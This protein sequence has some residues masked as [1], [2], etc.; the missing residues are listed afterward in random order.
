MPTPKSASAAK[1]TFLYLISF[2]A[3]GFVA[4]AVGSLFFEIINYFFPEEIDSWKNEFSQSQLKFS[5]ASLIIT[6]PIYFF[7]NR[8]INKGL[9]KKELNFESGVRKWLTYI[10]LFI[11]SAILVGDLISTIFHFLD[12]E[13]TVRFILKAAVLFLIAGVIFLY[14]FLDIKSAKPKKKD[15]LWGIGFW[16]FVLVPFISAFF[17]VENP[18][19]T[20]LKKI[21]RQVVETLN[22]LQNQIQ[23]FAH[24]KERI[25][26]DLTEL[27][28]FEGKPFMEGFAKKTMGKYQIE[29]HKSDDKNY[30]L[31][32]EFQRDNREDPENEKRYGAF[33]S[34]WLHDT[35]YFCFQLKADFEK[36][37]LE[38][39]LHPLP[40]EKR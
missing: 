39:K 17:I 26:E 8:L 20:R 1:H 34:Q 22:Q 6:A 24:E 27:Q 19:V 23:Y 16:I 13:L 37:P 11:V 7:I 35:G 32:G 28:S 33:E 4:F 31:C 30:E 29:Y 25:P 21:D 14:Y 9:V 15:L 38:K 3:L 36:G 2:L 40:V 10:A 18:K 12:G 5:I